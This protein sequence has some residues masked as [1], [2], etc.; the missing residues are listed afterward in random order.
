MT[1]S[2]TNDELIREALIYSA[3]RNSNSPA[4]VRRILSSRFSIEIL[5]IEAEAV[6]S[7]MAGE[8]VLKLAELARLRGDRP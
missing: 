6:C 3:S 2:S 4:A 8:S 1:M 5:E 7:R